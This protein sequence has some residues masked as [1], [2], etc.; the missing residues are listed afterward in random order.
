MLECFQY[1]PEIDLFESRV[2]TQ[3]LR[4]FSCRPDPFAEVTLGLTIGERRVRTY[5]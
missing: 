5:T 4:I 3:L 2:N 1:Y